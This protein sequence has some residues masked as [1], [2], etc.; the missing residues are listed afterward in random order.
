MEVMQ[1]QCKGNGSATGKTTVFTS[2][3]ATGAATRYKSRPNPLEL[4]T[5][6][7]I[8]GHR[9]LY[10]DYKLSCII[11]FLALFSSNRVHI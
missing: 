9:G 11:Q 2:F 7:K 6:L 4:D 1:R 5:L 3:C 10:N 8:D